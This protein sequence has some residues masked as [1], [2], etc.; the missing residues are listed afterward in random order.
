[1]ARYQVKLFK[2]LLS[3][4]GHPSHCRQST[5]DVDASGL[6][7]AVAQ[8]LGALGEWA[9]DCSISVNP[10]Y[11]RRAVLRPNARAQSQP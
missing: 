8:V 10:A 7:S 9:R 4:D 2:D 5:T 11:V 6:E 1:M 3:A